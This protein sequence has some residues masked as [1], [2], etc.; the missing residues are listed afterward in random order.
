MYGLLLMNDGEMGGIDE[1]NDKRNLRIAPVVFG[2]GE[3]SEIR[4]SESFLYISYIFVRRFFGP[5]I[6]VTHQYLQPHPH[7][8]Q[9]KRSHIL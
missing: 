6:N 8:I 7:P 2:I 5:M 9:R 3:D 1:R 4:I